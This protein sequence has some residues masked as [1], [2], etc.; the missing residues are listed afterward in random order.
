EDEVL[1]RR[2]CQNLRIGRV[3]S[4]P[5]LLHELPQR[6]VLSVWPECHEHGKPAIGVGSIH[7]RLQDRAVS[8]RHIGILFQE[9]FIPPG[10]GYPTFPSSAHSAL[11][12]TP[13]SPP[14]TNSA[15]PFR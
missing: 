1:A 6:H 3:Q 11:I 14:A 2:S 5:S 4:V 12:G 9:H 13:L 7:V 10:H 8:H 15:R